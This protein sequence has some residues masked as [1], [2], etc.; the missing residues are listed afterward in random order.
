MKNNKFGKNCDLYLKNVAQ[1]IIYY[2]KYI[3][4]IYARDVLVQE[5]VLMAQVAEII[6]YEG[7][8]NTFIWKHPSEDFNSHT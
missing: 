6:K 8:N 5:G 3:Y 1:S 4:L 2:N 7:D